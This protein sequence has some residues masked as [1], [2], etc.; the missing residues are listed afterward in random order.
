M[1]RKL[2]RFDKHS[3]ES[4]AKVRAQLSKLNFEKGFK[5]EVTDTKTNTFTT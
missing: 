5:I 3:E 2:T 4:L 1:V